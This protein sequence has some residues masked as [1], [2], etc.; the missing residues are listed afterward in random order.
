M[1]Q[2]DEARLFLAT[3]VDTLVQCRHCRLIYVNPRPV[4]KDTD[5]E[6]VFFL[7]E[8]KDVYGV[9]YIED[10][11]NITRLAR[12]RL[13]VIERHQQGG[14]LLDVGC[15]AGFLLDEARRRGWEPSG[16]EISHFASQYARQEL[17][18]DVFTGTLEEAKF[19]QAEFDVVVLYFVLEH[20]RDPLALLRE[21]SRILKPGGLLSLAV[22][23]IAGLYFRFKREDW[24]AERIRHQSHFYEF[25]P[26]TLRRMLARAGLRTVALTS[27]GRYARG[28]V[29]AGWV[30]RLCLGNV[31]LAHAVKT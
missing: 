3:P 18:L 25:S 16:V 11:A 26:S 12:A 5:Y 28:H 29:L 31:L 30:K 2:S 24:I 6:E 14:N 17:N 27:E 21:I 22:P 19:P 1:C 8:Y 20:L 9:D 13:D 10:R 15:A 4:A 23:N 7:Q